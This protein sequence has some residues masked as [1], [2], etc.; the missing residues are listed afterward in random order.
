MMN[1]EDYALDVG[2]T[3][4]EIRLYVIRLESNIKMKLHL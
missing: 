3:V 4:E 1:I 2:K